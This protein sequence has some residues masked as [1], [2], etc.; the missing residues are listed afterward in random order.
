MSAGPSTPFDAEG[1]FRAPAPSYVGQLRARPDTLVLGPEV[2][3]VRWTIRIQAADLY[4]AVRLSVAPSEG[5]L[6]CKTAA[7]RALLPNVEHHQD[8]ALKLHGGEV[9]DE[10]AT[11]AETGATDGSI[12][13]LVHRRRR[14]VR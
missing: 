8:F 10:A 14:P 7:L 3:G 9:R 4:D 1:A 12:F 13:V 2:A 11:L 5:I 6:A